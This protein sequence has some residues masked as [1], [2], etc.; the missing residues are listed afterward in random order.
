MMQRPTSDQLWG[1]NTLRHAI[2]AGLGALLIS[3]AAAS[4]ADTGVVRY[5]V[6]LFAGENQTGSHILIDDS[7]TTLSNNNFN[8][9]VV[10]VDVPEGWQARFY[11]HENFS[12]RYWTREAGKHNLPEGKIISSIEILG[13]ADETALA[14]NHVTV[15][16]DHDQQGFKSF[17][18]TNHN[19]LSNVLLDDKIRSFSIPPAWQ[20]RFFADENLSGP[21]WTRS[22]GQDNLPEADVISSI[23]ILTKPD[24]IPTKED[25]LT[26]RPTEGNDLHLPNDA[27]QIRVEMVDGG[28]AKNTFLPDNPKIGTTITVHRSSTWATYVVMPGDPSE[29]IEVPGNGYAVFVWDGKEWQNIVTASG[30][31]AKFKGKG[32]YDVTINK[33][34]PT[35]IASVD[36]APGA[37]AALE[38]P[39]VVTL[40]DIAITDGVL[41]NKTPYT[42]E[43]IYVELAGVIT[44]LNFLNPVP[45]YSSARL[46]GEWHSANYVHMTRLGNNQYNFASTAT[47]GRP[48]AR[49]ANDEERDSVE[50][51]QMYDRYWLNAPG[52]MSAITYRV[53]NNCDTNSGYSEC[54]NYGE[55]YLDYAADMYFAH[56]ASGMTSNFWIDPT[57]WGL[58][59]VP[60]KRMVKSTTDVSATVWMSPNLMANMLSSN[61]DTAVDAEQGLIHEYYHNL[62]FSHSSGW[63]SNTGI[64]DLFGYHA[65]H[66]FR[67][68]LGD[69]YTTS[70]LVVTV[71]RVDPL[72]Y[73]F[74]T[75]ALGAVSDLSI[76]LLSTD[77]ISGEV[78]ENDDDSVTVQFSQMPNTDV[79]VSFYSNESSQMATVALTDFVT[80]VSGQGALSNL[81]NT[82]AELVNQYN[83][84]FINTAN[85][86]WVRHFHLPA[87]REGR[88]VVFKSNAGYTSTIHY[89]EQQDQ[90]YTGNRIEYRFTDGHWVHQLTPQAPV[91]ETS[92]SGQHALSD[93]ERNF[94]GL[95][96]KYDKVL[97]NTADGSWVRHF[98][99]PEAEEGRTVVFKSNAGYTSTIHYGEQQDQLY[100]GNHIEYRFT[101]DHWVRQ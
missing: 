76:R 77:I 8:D 57:T 55:S 73:T 6:A 94:A 9:Q 43:G 49:L 3:Q 53:V 52:T 96:N 51:V 32:L 92:V 64:D 91:T 56:S 66:K 25:V 68:E 38:R 36:I 26:I 70:N 71:E 2:R 46:D 90:L 84:V 15:F 63:A 80:E 41:H 7:Q 74:K 95:V 40:K 72:K 50:R 44:Y 85:G 75:H 48:E 10:S 1:G 14:Q 60:G 88:V 69:R 98:H 23:A 79:Y 61:A 37:I 13:K 47:T 101:H 62:G 54:L 4:V 35:D 87:G 58:A 17:V 29:S 89:G 59:T 27:L 100:T 34:Q 65:Y 31:S 78:R 30:Q 42:L 24:Q 93:L 18:A 20:V 33:T 11:E 21:Y 99:L 67:S 97:I 45:E 81:E 5:S 28:W 82:F 83:K 22:A 16:T 86:S 12:G 39:A 19:Q